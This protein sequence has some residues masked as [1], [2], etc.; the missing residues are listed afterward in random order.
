M[1][2]YIQAVAKDS[3]Y[4]D[5][6]GD[7]SDISFSREQLGKLHLSDDDSP[8]GKKHSKTKRHHLISGQTDRRRKLLSPPPRRDEDQQA[9]LRK[10]EF[11][12]NK[13]RAEDIVT[14]AERSKAH[15]V[16]LTG[17]SKADDTD[18]TYF[19]E[20]DKFFH[21]MAHVDKALKDKIAE[22]WGRHRSQQTLAQTETH[23]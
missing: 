5:T 3:D 19:K 15:I 18:D 13:R 12:R 16:R 17:N 1:T 6:S 8:N 11:A 20:D 10:E 7:S 14:D 4:Q 23:Q 9:N 22:G 21:I 2:I